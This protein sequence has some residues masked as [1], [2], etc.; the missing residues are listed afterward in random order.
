MGHRAGPHEVIWLNAAEAFGFLG[1]RWGFEGPER[2][3]LGVAFHRLGLHIRIEFVAWKH[4][5]EF[6]TTVSMTVPDGQVRR[7]S[8]DRLYLACGLGV[9]QDVPTSEGPS[10]HTIVK[11]IGQHAAALRQLMPYL[12]GP[13]AA[14]LFR[15]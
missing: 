15:R 4:E 10:R 11:R 12:D 8:L 5:A 1:E 2:T 13:N 7:A 14:A 3:S 6:L 9:A